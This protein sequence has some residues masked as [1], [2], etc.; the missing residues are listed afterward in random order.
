VELMLAAMFMAIVLGVVFRKYE[1][2]W[3]VLIILLSI[4]VTTLYFVFADSMM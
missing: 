1:R 2:V 3:R 4:G